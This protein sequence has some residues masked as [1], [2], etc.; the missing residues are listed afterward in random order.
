MERARKR[1]EAR[2][3]PEKPTNES[4]KREIEVGTVHNRD[5]QLPTERD[6]AMNRGSRFDSIREHRFLAPTRGRLPL[7]R[8]IL[9]VIQ[10]WKIATK[11]NGSD[12]WTC[13]TWALVSNDGRAY[14]VDLFKQSM[15]YTEG[16]Q[17]VEEISVR[18]KT[19][20]VLIEN[21]GSGAKI[22]GDLQN[23]DIP[24]IPLSLTQSDKEANASAALSALESGFVTLPKYAEWPEVYLESLVHST[25]SQRDSDFESTSQA[26]KLLQEG[27]RAAKDH[28][29]NQIDKNLCSNP[30]CNVGPARKRKKLNSS[31]EIINAQGNRYCSV[32]CKCEHDVYLGDQLTKRR[33]PQE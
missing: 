32:F 6:P 18:W 20:A 22:I 14:L 12:I 21:A 9:L 10:S 7:G 5:G 16:R 2:D 24:V 23:T 33:T 4:V 29:A 15:D 26:L 11:E 13:T 27:P 31:E 28:I 19:D 25:P 3:S 8:E 17:K 1:V 30:K